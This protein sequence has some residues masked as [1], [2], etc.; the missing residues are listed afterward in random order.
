M[1]AIGR[2]LMSNPILLFDEISL[3]LAPIIMGHLRACRT[4]SARHA[5]D[6]RRA[7]H[8][9]GAEAASRV[10][11]LQEGRIALEGGRG[12][13]RATHLSALIS[14]CEMTEWLNVIL[15]GVLIGGLYAHVRRRPVADLRRHAA[16]QHRAWRPDRAGRFRRTDGD[17]GARPRTAHLARSRRAGDGADR[18]RAATRP[19][20]P[21][22]RR[23]YAAAAARHLRPVDHHPERPVGT[24]H[25]RQPS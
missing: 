19:A 10:Y 20:Q 8:H 25:R 7:G 14:G 1:A 23:R 13:R 11:C 15:Q 3:G 21:H 17:Q 24:V 5:R 16:R 22:A 18:L 6:H 9:P 4:S 12:D 2:A